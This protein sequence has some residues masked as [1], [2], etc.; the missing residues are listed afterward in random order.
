MA[1][2]LTE[3]NNI[4]PPKLQFNQNPLPKVADP[5]I[6]FNERSYI[7]TSQIAEEHNPESVFKMNKSFS[8]A[9][10]VP[11]LSHFE[12]KSQSKNYMQGG[13]TGDVSIMSKERDS[14]ERYL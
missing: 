10:P 6:N 13:H 8:N 5:Q 11:K 7:Q 14:E 1:S 2:P 3:H 9:S 12:A 4:R